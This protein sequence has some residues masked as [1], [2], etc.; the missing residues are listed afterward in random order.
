MQSGKSIKSLGVSTF[1]DLSKLHD[2]KNMYLN[3]LKE[4][5]KIK[6]S[7]SMSNHKG[8]NI[9]T[10]ETLTLLYAILSLP[11]LNLNF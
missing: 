2:H 3:I 1:I 8:K 7:K 6:K 5:K 10:S 11:S 4:E 9:S